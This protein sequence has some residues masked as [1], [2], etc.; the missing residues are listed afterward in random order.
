MGTTQLMPNPK[1]ITFRTRRKSQKPIT[2]QTKKRKPENTSQNK[3]K[4]QK[5][6]NIFG[7][8]LAESCVDLWPR[9]RPDMFFCKVIGFRNVFLSGMRLSCSA[10]DELQGG[11]HYIVLLGNLLLKTK[12]MLKQHLK[13]TIK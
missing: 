3:K 7:V 6:N 10:H 1:P 8:T 12:I 2:F 4:Q 9:V 11:L 13:Q 5:H